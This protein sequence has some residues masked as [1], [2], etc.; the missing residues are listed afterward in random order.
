MGTTCGGDFDC[1][2]GGRFQCQDRRQAFLHH[3]FGAFISRAWL[4][5]EI[6]SWQ[7]FAVADSDAWEAGFALMGS[8]KHDPLSFHSFRQSTIVEDYS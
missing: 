5:Q 2:I 4:G 7:F 8:C 1:V 3:R 6:S